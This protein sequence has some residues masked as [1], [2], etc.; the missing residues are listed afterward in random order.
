MP[1]MIPADVGEETP[2]AAEKILFDL[3]SAMPDTDNW[4]VMHSVGIARHPAQSQGEGDFV[5][6]IPGRATLTLEVKGGL[7]SLH[8]GRWYSLDIYDNDHLIRNPVN[9]SSLANQAFKTF[10][11][12]SPKN[13]SER[14]E[15]TIFGFGVV[16]P[17]CTFHGLFELVDLADEQIA[18]ADDC[19]SP[20][21]LRDYLIRLAE[22][23]RVCF[24]STPK[25]TPPTPHQSKLIVDILRPEFDARLSLGSIVKKSEAIADALTQEQLSVLDGL[26]ENDRC[27]IKGGAGTGKTTLAVHLA[28]EMHRA[29]KRVGLFCFNCQL[30][31]ELQLSTAD[32]P[33][34]VSD[35]LTEYMESVAMCAGI[36]TPDDTPSS[37]SEFY[38]E[39]LPELF[40]EAFVDL[41]LP[42]LDIIILDEGQ[43]LM[44][45]RFL[46]AMD[47]M[48]KGGL[49]DGSWFFFM[50][51]E[52]QDLYKAAGD[53]EAVKAELRSRG[54]SYVNYRLT[55]NCR[56]TKAIAEKIDS[57]FGTH[58]RQKSGV[59]AGEPVRFQ[60]Y[61]DEDEE[62]AQLAAIL[63]KLKRDGVSD[64]QIAILSPL[65][66]EHSAVRQ[67]EGYDITIDYKHRG[68]R[69]LFSTV[70]T[71]KG[72][73]SPVVILTDI[74]RFTYDNNKMTL[75]IGMSRAKSLL[76]VLVRDSAMKL[77]NEFA[78]KAGK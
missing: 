33:Q 17:E 43:D 32:Q 10:V 74:D 39:E 15:S 22:Y 18:D 67:L 48:L 37:V 7:I 72:L 30:A 62:R 28:K 52:H 65:R 5:I 6:T 41:E 76:Y 29:G 59:A 3:L 42:Q 16:F 46:D 55:E 14:L 73:S 12:R 71:Y 75:Y 23:W 11:S 70:H 9:E 64:D 69:I 61:K 8:E 78:E 47:W 77:I 51:A 50:D 31:S 2:S 35:S 38:Q 36:V 40:L 63:E 26:L 13:A 4:T 56:N 60:T 68:G 24:R 54:A 44:R 21:A 19:C 49:K 58:T 66:L 45:P 20:G 57:I 53:E 25:V 27:L 34:I 1:R